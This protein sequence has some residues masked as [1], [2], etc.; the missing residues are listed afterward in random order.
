VWNADGSRIAFFSFR[1]QPGIYQRASNG[2]GEDELLF[3][4]DQGQVFIPSAEGWSR[5]G[6]FMLLT[7][8]PGAASGVNLWVLALIGASAADR[9]VVPLVKSEVRARGGRFSPDNRWVA[10][11]SSKTGKDEAYVRAF[12]PNF[13]S[14]S[15]NA[16]P[17]GEYVISKAG[18][19][20]PHWS[21][22]GKEIFYIAPDGGVMAVD[23]SDKTKPGIPKPLFKV[24]PGVAFWDVANDRQSQRFL[25][26]LAGGAPS[27]NPAPYKVLL[28]WTST[29]KH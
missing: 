3:K 6:R 18:G 5:D 28:N 23:V 1:K 25:I 15:R 8:N 7:S 11:T 13:V 17:G 10:Y 22:D 19:T 2:A 26:P 12:D 9:K 24:P 16:S 14:G 29:L 27:G 21:G 4:V 20:S